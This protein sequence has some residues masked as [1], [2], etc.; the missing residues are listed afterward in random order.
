MGRALL[1]IIAAGVVTLTT[2]A[3]VIYL[4]VWLLL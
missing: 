2:L 1:G 4:S 3:T